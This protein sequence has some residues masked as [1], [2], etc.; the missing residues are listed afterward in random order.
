M[1]SS[2]PPLILNSSGQLTELIVYITSTRVDLCSH[3]ILLH[4]LLHAKPSFQPLTCQIQ[5]WSVWREGCG[6]TCRCPGALRAWPWLSVPWWGPT[7]N[8][9]RLYS[10]PSNLSYKPHQIQKLKCFS[11]CLAAVFANPLKL[12]KMSNISCTK[13]PNLNVHR[14]V[15]QLYL[16]KLGMKS[17]MKM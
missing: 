14:L 8:Q 15:L 4:V 7:D 17:R 9:N 3:Q 10:V 2:D 5:C 16:P 13:S 1:G 6:V 11:S 12:P